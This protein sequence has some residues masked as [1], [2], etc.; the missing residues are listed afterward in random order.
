VGSDPD[1]GF[2]RLDEHLARLSASAEYFG[3]AFDDDAVR[4]ALQAEAVRFSGRSAKIRLLLD[5]RG[6][7][8][9][10]GAPMSVSEGPVRLSIDTGHAVDPLDVLLFHKTSLRGP[11]EEAR[12]RHPDA[13]DAV[14]V[15]TR[16]EVTETTTS[17]LAVRL[18][19]RWWTPPLNAGLLPGCERTALLAE[20]VVDERSVTI[21][22]LRSAMEIAVLNSVRG[23][24]A[25][26]VVD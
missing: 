21:D 10:G 24:R 6:R 26:V 18:D 8:Q 13:D 12:A 14:L 20:G 19:G 11:Y 23:W 9:T 2:R 3:F 25:A 17:N 22:D 7:V 4:E 15:N 1:L 5:R 16:G